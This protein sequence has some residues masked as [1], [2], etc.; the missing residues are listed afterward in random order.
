[1]RAVLQRVHSASVTVDGNKV[2]TCGKGLVALVGAH[3]EDTLENAEKLADRI[4]GIRIFSDSEGKMNLGFPDIETDQTQV[5]AISNFTVF[6][7]AVKSRRPSFTSSAGYEQGKQLFDHFVK[8]LQDKEITVE[9]GVFGEMMDVELI[10]DG[11][12]TLVLDC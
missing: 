8:S 1:M 11:P 12:V 9:T 2:G 5:L 7:D 4:A 6:G 3:K 10:N